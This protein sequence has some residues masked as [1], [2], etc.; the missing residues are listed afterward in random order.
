[1]R[2]DPFWAPHRSL[3]TIEAVMMLVIAGA[4]GLERALNRPAFGLVER[5]YY[6]AMFG[7]LGTVAALLLSA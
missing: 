6:L 3:L 5:V 4:T 2:L 1:V 7:W